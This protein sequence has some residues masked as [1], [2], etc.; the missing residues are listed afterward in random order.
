MGRSAMAWTYVVIALAVAGVAAGILWPAGPAEPAGNPGAGKLAP[1][2]PVTAEP[3]DVARYFASDNFAALPEASKREYFGAAVKEYE[4]RTDWIRRMFELT[5]QQRDRL[6][7][8]MRPLFRDLMKERIGTYNTLPDEKKG[9]YLDRMIDQ[10][11]AL[12]KAMKEYRAELKKA[13]K[14]W[15]G[16]GEP[17]GEFTPARLKKRME[18]TSPEERARM[19]EFM[20]DVMARMIARKLTF[21]PPRPPAATTDDKKDK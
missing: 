7:K 18:E 2:D 13:G 20:K 21:W 3:L 5:K 11:L 14:K 12:R 15:P 17:R 4:V 19:T 1:P 9:P 6:R 10:G 8:N 16:G